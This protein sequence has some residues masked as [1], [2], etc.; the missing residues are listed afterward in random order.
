MNVIPLADARALRGA[1]RRS[2]LL[3]LV[4]VAVLAAVL[5]LFAGLARTGTGPRP[6]V[7]AGSAA[8]VVIDVSSST[9][10]AARFI[11]STLEPLTRD[12]SRQ[13]GL[14]LFSNTAYEALP[15]STPV[16]GL[17][18]W[19]DRF[20][21]ETPKTSPWASF[22]S[23]TAIS[24]G[25]VLAHRLLRSAHV[26]TPHVILVSD[27]VDTGSDVPEL[28]AIVAR[29]QREAI[30]L[31]IVKIRSHAARRAPDLGFVERAA[32]ATVEPARSGGGAP[33]L[34]LLAALVAAAALLAAVYELA[35]HPLTWRP[36]T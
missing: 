10:S 7:P 21:R 28:Q 5:A 34:A 4:L 33:R 18:G 13:V 20:A 12:P 6:L 11:S 19:L 29:Y 26:A 17:K 35:F 22:S 27:L 8:V 23:G 31:K 1:V 2:S 32:S 25:L 15:P 9:R 24:S 3:W 16:D 36:A 30:D 14:V